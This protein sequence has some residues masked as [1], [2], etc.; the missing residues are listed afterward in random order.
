MTTPRSASDHA[1]TG[2]FDY[3][4]FHAETRA[5]WRAWLSGNHAAARG[6]WLCSWRAGRPRCPYPEAVEEAICFGWID[7]TTTIL[8]D[9]RG[10]QL[11][12]PRRAKSPWTRLNRRRAAEMAERGLMTDA[13]VRAIEA[14]KSNGWWTIADP[15][16]DLEEPPALAAA[17]DQDPRARAHWDKF[18]PS[19]RKQM[20]WWIVSA[21]RD[22]TRA[23]RIAQI[24]AAARE[25]RRARG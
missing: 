8:D 23:D 7:S 15:V 19:A 13:G 10:L 22:A 18:P 14:A 12:T 1:A 9:E 5:Q 24:V 11:F 4:I 21:A 3:P 17:L 25:G 20:L 16:E 6:V 2:K